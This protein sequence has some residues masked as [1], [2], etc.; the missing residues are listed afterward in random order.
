MD[1]IDNSRIN[2]CGNKLGG[3][4][5]GLSDVALEAGASDSFTNSFTDSFAVS[6]TSCDSDADLRSEWCRTEW[7]M[8]EVASGGE[9]RETP[10]ERVAA[11]EGNAVQL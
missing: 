7:Q 3:S 11:A 6:T 10:T 4:F 5:D 9:K 1:S 2:S 8:E